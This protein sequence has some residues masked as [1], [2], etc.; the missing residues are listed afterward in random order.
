MAMRQH[1]LLPERG[2]VPALHMRVR[3]AALKP[4]PSLIHC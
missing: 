2:G 1:Y 4:N 3:S